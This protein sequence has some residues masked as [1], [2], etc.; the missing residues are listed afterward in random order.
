[1]YIISKQTKQFVLL[2]I[3][4]IHHTRAWPIHRLRSQSG[5]IHNRPHHRLFSQSASG[6]SGNCAIGQALQHTSGGVTISVSYSSYYFHIFDISIRSV[7]NGLSK[8]FTHD[9]NRLQRNLQTYRMHVDKPSYSLYCIFRPNKLKLGINLIVKNR[10][11]QPL[12]CRVFPSVRNNCSR[13]SVKL[14]G[15]ARWGWQKLHHNT[16]WND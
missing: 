1:M 11:L 12:F 8:D 10:S 14:L 16:F 2:H 9:Q 3:C 7:L 6:Q 5:N 15:F 4:T 13:T